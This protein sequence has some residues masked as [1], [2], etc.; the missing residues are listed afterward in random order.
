MSRALCE[1]SALEQRV[2]ERELGEY[3][4]DLMHFFRIESVAWMAARHGYGGAIPAAFRITLLFAVLEAL[5]RAR[6]PVLV[7]DAAGYRVEVAGRVRFAVPWSAVREVRL[8]RAE[9]AA[10][11]DCGDKARNLLLP[12]ERGYAFSYGDQAALLAAVLAAV[13]PERVRE[14]QKLE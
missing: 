8:D 9:G 5:A 1:L 4:D 10:Y 13:P 11:V 3:C 2:F 7:C 14:V 12:P 6:R